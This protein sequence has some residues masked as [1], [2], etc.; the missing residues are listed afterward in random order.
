MQVI[1]CY[2]SDTT[3]SDIKLLR[4]YVGTDTT[5]TVICQCFK[6]DYSMAV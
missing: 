4:I 6:D 5:V 1:N 2:E 3:K